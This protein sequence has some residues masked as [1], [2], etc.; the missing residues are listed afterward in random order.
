MFMD[1]DN[2][3][4][5][6]L[7]ENTSSVRAAE[8]VVLGALLLLAG[9]AVVVLT[10]VVVAVVYM[11]DGR[12]MVLVEYASRGMI[13][14]GVVCVCVSRMFAMEEGSQCQRLF[15]IDN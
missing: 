8:V 2:D 5:A 12:A 4:D 3:V 11:N 1:D 6:M 15:A 14:F 9:V 7:F 13:G 10:A